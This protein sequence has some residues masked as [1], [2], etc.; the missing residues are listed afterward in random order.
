MCR[1][2]TWIT[3]LRM[4]LIFLTLIILS[5]VIVSCSQS[6]KRYSGYLIGLLR[7]LTIKSGKKI[8]DQDSH[9]RNFLWDFAPQNPK[10]HCLDTF[11]IFNFFYIL[12]KIQKN[13]HYFY[14]IFR[15]FWWYFFMILFDRFLAFFYFVFWL[16]S[17]AKFKIAEIGEILI[18]DY[19]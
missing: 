8:K 11:L 9:R 3:I 7:N 13:L 4:I 2:V 14:L 19:T 16:F 1:F 17:K 15:I 5:Y 12:R 10:F 18:A 6:K